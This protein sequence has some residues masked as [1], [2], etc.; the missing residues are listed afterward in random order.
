MLIHAVSNWIINKLLLTLTSSPSLVAELFRPWCTKQCGR[1]RMWYVGDLRPDGAQV[2]RFSSWG[3]VVPKGFLTKSAYISSRT[4]VTQP[5]PNQ[6]GHHR[7]KVN[8]RCT[9]EGP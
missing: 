7:I 5:L 8:P 9:K 1:P 6:R 3:T 2:G 4:Q